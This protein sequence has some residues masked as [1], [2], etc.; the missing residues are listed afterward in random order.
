MLNVRCH[1]FASAFIP[2]RL[3]PPS[4]IQP[5][6]AK[7]HGLPT[8]EDFGSYQPATIPMRTGNTAGLLL[9]HFAKCDNPLKLCSKSCGFDGFV[10]E[11]ETMHSR[12]HPACMGENVWV[13][14][15]RRF[16]QL[17][18]IHHHHVNWEQY[19]AVSATLCKVWQSTGTLRQVVRT[20]WL[21]WLRSGIEVFALHQ[22]SSLYGQKRMG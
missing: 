17:P 3:C 19:G 21:R 4:N 15:S 7:T 6:W 12:K 11:S 5:V 8:V 18:A 13:T 2:L 22:T 1:W 20:R 16:Q 14:N 10:R 9:P